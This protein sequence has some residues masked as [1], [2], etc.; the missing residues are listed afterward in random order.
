MGQPDEQFWMLDF[1]T[2][3]PLWLLSVINVWGT[4]VNNVWPNIVLFPTALFYGE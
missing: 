4:P 3:D 2:S 1:T